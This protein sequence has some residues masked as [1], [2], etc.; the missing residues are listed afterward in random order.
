MESE[1]IGP[2]GWMAT[3]WND[4]SPSV[5]ISPTS[6]QQPPLLLNQPHRLLRQRTSRPAY[7]E[8]SRPRT[9]AFPPSN[10]QRKTVSGRFASDWP[11]PCGSLVTGMPARTI[12]R[13]GPRKVVLTAER[14]GQRQKLMPSRTGI[15]LQKDIVGTGAASKNIEVEG[16]S[17]SR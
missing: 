10:G 6:E 1:L 7:K 15:G 4:S 16:E 5:C 8:R 13:D 14:Q 11:R 9:M 2:S 12:A 3:D 17:V